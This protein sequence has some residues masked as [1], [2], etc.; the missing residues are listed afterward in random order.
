MVR[1]L[2][3]VLFGGRPRFSLTGP[4]GASSFVGSDDSTGA[5]VS[6]MFTVS[7]MFAGSVISAGSVVPVGSSIFQELP[8][9]NHTRKLNWVGG[10]Q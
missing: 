7:V 2:A 4:V 5:A 10:K 1:V 9:I 8:F 3:L 6:V